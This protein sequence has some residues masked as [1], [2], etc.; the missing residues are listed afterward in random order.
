MIKINKKGVFILIDAE[1]AEKVNNCKFYL[2]VDKRSGYKR[3]RLYNG[4]SLASLILN[5]S[6][7]NEVDHIN[8]DTLD[9][10][11]S[12]LRVC[13]HSENMFNRKIN[14]NNTSGY[15]GV[16]WI[17]DKNCWKTEINYKGKRIRKHFKTKIDA[18]KFYNE[19]ALKYFG[20]FARLNIIK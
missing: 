2:N 14:K 8:G 5:C 1:D 20:N 7:K 10:R 18:A 3:V 9:N 12:N 4:K 11:K 15:K 6:G 19:S 17:K 16:S 13:S